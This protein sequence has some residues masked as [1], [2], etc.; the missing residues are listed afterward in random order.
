MPSGTEV[1]S[2]L[3]WLNKFNQLCFEVFHSNP[4]GKELLEHMEQKFFRSP[5]A[6]PNMEP[7][8]AYFNEGKNEMLR[9]FTVGIQNYMNTPAKTAESKQYKRVI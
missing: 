4:K 8:W 3:E 9:S 6:F 1:R 2:E 7:S 5:V